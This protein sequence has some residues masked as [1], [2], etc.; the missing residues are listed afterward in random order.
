MFERY[1]N[2]EIPKV[3]SLAEE[4]ARALRHGFIGT[5][6]F[7][8]GLL[9]LEEGIAAQVLTNLGMTLKYA[10]M[11]VEIIIGRGSASSESKEFFYTPRAKRL[12]E[13][14]L[15]EASN[16]GH[17]YVGGEHLLLALTGSDELINKGIAAYIINDKFG[18]DSTLIRQQILEILAEKK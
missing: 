10:R 4:E 14:A 16:L 5:E 2:P 8:L 12:L 7:L 11:D 1:Y 9:R 6:T 3:I 17:N 18:L 15:E 13:F